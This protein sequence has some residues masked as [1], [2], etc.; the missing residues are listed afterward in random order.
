M[1][2]T[3][4]ASR[5]DIAD[6]AD[7]IF[8]ELNVVAWQRYS[9]PGQAPIRCESSEELKQ[10]ISSGEDLFSLWFPEVM[11]LPSIRTIDLHGGN[12]RH[13]VEGC[14]LFFLNLGHM[15]N[16]LLCASDLSWF[17]EAG[18]KAK[19]TVLPGPEA[20]DWA[21]HKQVGARLT[22]LIRRLK[23]ASA[24]GRPILRGAWQMHLE[25]ALFKEHRNAPD[26]ISPIAT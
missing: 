16:S 12:K 26:S 25:G 24:P 9:T 22:S 18:A 21:R 5:T 10:L 11:P 7:E 13:V 4:F 15:T 8:S 20:T 14:G 3:F 23:V 1:S 19:C 6:L 2:S 17:T